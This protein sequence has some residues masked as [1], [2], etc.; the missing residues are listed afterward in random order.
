VVQGQLQFYVTAIQCM[1]EIKKVSVCKIFVICLT[2]LLW[3]SRILHTEPSLDML[4]VS[5]YVQ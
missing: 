3:T 4:C 1:K 5:C 2:A